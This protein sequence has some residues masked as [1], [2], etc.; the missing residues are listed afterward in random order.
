MPAAVDTTIGQCAIE[1]GPFCWVQADP[2]SLAWAVDVDWSG[3]YRA[4]IRKAHTATSPKLGEF[5]I[6]AT[7]DGTLTHFT[8]AMTEEASELIPVGTY[9][10]DLQQ[11]GGVTRVW[12]KVLVKPQITVVV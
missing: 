12:G 8:M 10:T 9:Y 3:E 2:V 4:E 7:F 11:V 5:I 1:I 6:T